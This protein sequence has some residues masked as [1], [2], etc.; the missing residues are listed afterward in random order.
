MSNIHKDQ[1]TMKVKYPHNSLR[2]QLSTDEKKRFNLYKK[3]E[4]ERRRRYRK[5]GKNAHKNI[6]MHRCEFCWKF[7]ETV[8]LLCG[9]SVCKKCPISFMDGK[10][11][12]VKHEKKK[13]MDVTK[14]NIQSLLLI[15]PKSQLNTTPEQDHENRLEDNQNLFEDSEMMEFE[16]DLYII[17]SNAD[18]ESQYGH[19]Q[20]RC[21]LPSIE[22]FINDGISVV[23]EHFSFSKINV[24]KKN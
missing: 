7:F 23:M 18:W 22:D 8:D 16:R 21:Y 10:P 4:C 14:D 11:I 13:L 12:F 9:Y 1:Q 17:Q 19:T 20:V 3:R 24:D 6:Y 2:K 15:S 5:S